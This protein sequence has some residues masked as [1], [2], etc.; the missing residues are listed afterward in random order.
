MA[1]SQGVHRLARTRR[2]VPIIDFER[3]RSAP[4]L[5]RGAGGR[6]PTFCT[7]CRFLVHDRRHCRRGVDHYSAEK[8]SAIISHSGPWWAS[9]GP[10]RTTGVAHTGEAVAARRTP[11]VFAPH[12]PH[13]SN[14]LPAN[15]T[16][17]DVSLNRTTKRHPPLFVFGFPF[18]NIKD[19][20]MY[21][22]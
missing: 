2:S 14:D 22:V 7:V 5:D 12:H 9:E 4:R 13:V 6:C 10:G 3:T 21:A 11:R 16:E 19:L 18:G 17:L 8:L 20:L 15:E 1:D